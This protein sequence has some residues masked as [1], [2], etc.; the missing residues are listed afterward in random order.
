MWIDPQT[1]QDS[2]VALGLATL[3]G[4]SLYATAFLTGLAMHFGW[5]PDF[6]H[7]HLL[8][9][10]GETP[11]LSFLFG[12]SAVEF[13]AGKVRFL[14]SIWDVLHTLIRPVGAAILAAHAYQHHGQAG[15]VLVAL[16][17]GTAALGTHSLRTA[18]NLA[19]SHL[20]LPF[21]NLFVGGAASIAFL[22]GYALYLMNAVVA[23]AAFAVVVAL[24]FWMVSKFGYRLGQLYRRGLAGLFRSQPVPEAQPNREGFGHPLPSVGNE[25]HLES[26]K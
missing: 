20:P 19:A 9:A 16:L 24:S 14:G 10:L 4:Y 26:Y 2:A 1:L 3:S 8:S 25:R 15:E 11:V 5:F 12:V 17:G 18:G 6:T 21:A 23:L 7:D 22:A 13:L